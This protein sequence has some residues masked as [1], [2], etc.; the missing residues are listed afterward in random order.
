[1]S[2]VTF[3]FDIAAPGG[4]AWLD[5]SAEDSNGSTGRTRTGPLGLQISPLTQSR[6]PY[7]F[8]GARLRGTRCI[9]TASTVSGAE[10]LRAPRAMTAPNSDGSVHVIARLDCGGPVFEPT[11]APTHGVLRVV[12][13]VDGIV[14]QFM[15]NSHLFT[16]N[17]PQAA[18]GLE[19]GMLAE[20]FDQTFELTAFQIQLLRSAAAL[21]PAGGEELNTPT[22]LV[23]VDRYLAALTGLLLRTAVRKPSGELEQLE[24]VR[25]RTD[26][27]IYEQAADPMLTPAVIAAQLNVSLRQLY[28]AFNGTESPAARIR[29]RRL[30]RAAELLAARSPQPQVE[31]VAQECGFASAE[32]FSR[33]FRREFGISPRAYR[34]AHRDAAVNR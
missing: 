1:V 7:F 11:G 9:W 24:S 25:A 32:Y 34:S 17:V 3:R 29:R 14:E 26:A 28:R 20:M 30:D 2:D 8:R 23:G 18:I 6:A 5:V 4:V 15:G 21:L 13:A 31:W 10:L 22:N 16:L 12:D 27:I 33:A 19:P